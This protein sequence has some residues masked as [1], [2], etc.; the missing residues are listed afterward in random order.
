M[1][2]GR[3]KCKVL[4]CKQCNYCILLF[5]ALLQ[6]DF[7]HHHGLQASL[8]RWALTSSCFCLYSPRKVQLA[9]DPLKSPG[10][11]GLPLGRPHCPEP[12]G[13]RRVRE[14]RQKTEE[15][16]P[17]L[18]PPGTHLGREFDE[19]QSHICQRNFGESRCSGV[20]GAWHRSPAP[21]DS[22]LA[23]GLFSFWSAA[24]ARCPAGL[25]KEACG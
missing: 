10:L 23:C 21:L 19:R 12:V 15:Q 11:A 18:V 5:P 25:L 8:L 9:M 16:G 17:T 6:S 13:Q 2:T 20:G 22:H 1:P 14:P 7:T 3:S 4:F 24:P